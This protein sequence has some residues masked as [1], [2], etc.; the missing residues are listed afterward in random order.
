MFDLR[1][2]AASLAAVFLALAVGVLLGVAISGK[3]SNT[4]ES[5]QKAIIEQ[6]NR[7]LAAERERTKAAGRRGEAAERVVED[8]YPSLMAGRLEGRRF[9]LLFLGGVDG[10]LRSA[11]E[12]TLADGD[13]GAPVR[14]TALALPLDP[15][16]LHDL[17]APQT[18]LAAYAADSDWSD[19]GRD[20]GRELVLGGATPLWAAVSGQLVGERSGTSFPPVDGVIV[21]RS[22]NA[23]PSGDVEAATRRQAS[24]R[25]I[26]GVLDGL[27]ATGVPVVGIE[28]AGVQAAASS[29][30]LYRERG[31]SS[32]DDADTVAG[33][34]ALA[35]LLA[36]GEPG[37]YGVKDSASD[38]VVPPIESVPAATTVGG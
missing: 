28:N 27:Q 3:V 13:S 15:K 32:V 24:E 26:V 21:V 12:R 19:L 18:T 10:G 8:A 34:L 11:V 29:I 37:H 30:D 9:A 17:L 4:Q 31:V 16:G 36:G 5:A 25:F 14:M 1:Y 7:D 20:L 6:L 35:L 2:H 23:S 38:G 33:R 22:W